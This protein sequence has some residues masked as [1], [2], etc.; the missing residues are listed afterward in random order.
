MH[1][2][3]VVELL[4]LLHDVNWEGRVDRADEVD[5]QARGDSRESN[6]GLG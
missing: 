1:V 3:S 4:N 2:D 6:P 5:W